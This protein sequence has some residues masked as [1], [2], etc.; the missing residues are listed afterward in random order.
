LEPPDGVVPFS[1]S[2][3]RW[4]NRRR[5]E[6]LLCYPCAGSI[7]S[8]SALAVRVPLA[9][10]DE[11]QGSWVVL[12]SR[13]VAAP[14]S[15]AGGV[16]SVPLRPWARWD[17]VRAWFFF[18]TIHYT[19]CQRSSAADVTHHQPPLRRGRNYYFDEDF[20]FRVCFSPR[21]GQPPSLSGSY[22]EQSSSCPMTPSG[23]SSTPNAQHPHK[24]NS[25]RGGAS[26]W[27]RR[28]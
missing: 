28:V 22:F 6:S 18:P 3:A 1:A 8:D 16:R 20:N 10:R 14:S 24:T 27:R 2:S 9:Q 23:D 13:E 19:T 15:V 26:A 5:T 12:H 21:A 25:H 17:W 11:I 4:E 7:V